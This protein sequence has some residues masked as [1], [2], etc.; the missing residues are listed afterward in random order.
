[1]FAT[2]TILAA[3]HAPDPG[4]NATDAEL[5]RRFAENRDEGAF[6][7]L[8]R[9]HARLV[10]G[11][12]RRTLI[13]L[14]DAE[15]AFQAAFLVLA[16]NPEK[17]RRSG[18]AAGFLFGVARRVALKTRTKVAAQRVRRNAPPPEGTDPA[19]ESAL[20]ELQLILDEEI[21]RL[22]EVCRVPFVL[23][24]LEGV[25]RAHAA[26][27]L[28]VNA[29]TLSSRLARA[30][31]LL[32]HRLAKRGVQ[33]AAALAV[34]D[35][36]SAPAAPPALVC[37]TVAAGVVH[38]GP[39]WRTALVAVPRAKRVLGATVGLVACVAVAVGL[40]G[41]GRTPPGDPPPVANEKPAGEPPVVADAGGDP[42]P[43]G[44]VGRLGSA[45]W[46]HEGEARF[47]SFSHDGKTL[48]LLGGENPSITFFETA[49]G[50]VVHRMDLDWDRS[51]YPG[52]IAFSPDG[53]FF[54]CRFPGG[55]VRLW[56]PQTKKLVHTL[57]GTPPNYVRGS[58]GHARHP[59]LFSPDGTRLAVCGPGASVTIWDPSKERST[60]ALVGHCHG[61]PPLAFS[62][63]GKIVFLAIGPFDGQESG[64]VQLWD[65]HTGKFLRKFNTGEPVYTLAVAPD[66]K[67]VA[68]GTPDQIIV[69]AVE[70]G[71]ELLR[72]EVKE[73]GAV[74]RVDLTPDG[75]SLISCGQDSKVRVWDLATKKAR[76]VLESSS[77]IGALAVSADGK[78]LAIGTKYNVV[79]VWD[80]S[81]GKELSTQVDGHDAPIL[82]LSFSPDG[83]SLVTAGANDQSRLWDPVT[84]RAIKLLK[85]GPATG[86]SFSP[87]GGRLVLTG[88]E[89]VLARVL[90]LKANRTVLELGSA[91][92][93]QCSCA[94]FAP[95]GKTIV[96]ASWLHEQGESGSGKTLVRVRDALTGKSQR[97]L[98]L[99][100]LNPCALA[101]SPDGRWAAVGGM[102]GNWR[103]DKGAPLR[104]CALRHDQVRTVRHGDMCWDVCVAFSPDSRI[105]AS[106]SLDRNTRLWEVTT[107]REIMTLTGHERSVTAVAFAPGGRVLVSADGG[108]VQPRFWEGRPPLS[109]RFWDVGTGKELARLGGHGSGVTALEFSPDGKR[110]VAGLNNGTALVWRVPAAAEP[111]VGA[112]RK[113][114][115]RE[116]GGLWQDLAGADAAVA[117]EAVRILAAS[118]EQSVPFLAT[119]LRPA[120]KIDAAKLRQR[121]ADLGCEE[122]AVR[123]AASKEL[124]ELGED[125]EGELVQAL[126][127]KP[128]P[129]VARRVQGLLAALRDAPPPERLRELRAV[130]AIE[131]CG[132]PAANKV[133]VELAKG[134]AD[135]RLTR[136]AKAAIERK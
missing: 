40:A 5:L 126:K 100:D 79:R 16:R 18:T 83:R 7:A 113:L 73:M 28:G 19:S 58:D 123:E 4:S 14:Q 71:K 129:E 97:E 96:T 38:R 8:V 120:E 17:P 27:T 104:I 49:T 45:R 6:E 69:S 68:C 110:L 63:D 24:V 88:D 125:I 118:P 82:A 56:D 94:A 12:C 48:A 117:H 85:T 50:K 54:A 53:K 116:L 60:A 121:L 135:A 72:L 26:E 91:E 51:D 21:A 111:P 74:V 10:W 75:K 124:A 42:L 133:L 11:V 99:A 108:C 9:R 67:S 105:V 41:T 3:I 61:N 87:D 112:G 77:G 93:E 70:T 106:G 136:E 78:M 43:A 22:P 15:D 134:H 64:Q 29:G 81:T 52:P 76:V 92:G 36:V 101:V 55:S 84:L 30:R 102:S 80:V 131:L 25:A 47:M 86:V 66:G 13:S 89:D 20:R 32:R 1:M 115:P 103:D 90:D 95:D 57:V 114:G 98:P 37:A 132:T 31:L 128:A 62:P 39:E 23:C 130:W 2:R 107:G 44:A 33:L 127:D 122:F 65:A 119:R 34:T 109:I 46:R 35:L 59:I